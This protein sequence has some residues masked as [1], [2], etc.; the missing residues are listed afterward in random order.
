MKQVFTNWPKLEVV[1][2]G[3][4]NIFC[5]VKKLPPD[6][7]QMRPFGQ[8]NCYP[9]TRQKTIY[10]QF[11]INVPARCYGKQILLSSTYF[12]LYSSLPGFYGLIGHKDF[13]SKRYASASSHTPR[14]KLF[15]GRTVKPRTYTF[16]YPSLN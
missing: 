2:K 10:S 6:K 4:D 11:L 8:R 9:G 1:L 14:A 16:F 7:F 15:L 3:P 13:M 12:F 5:H